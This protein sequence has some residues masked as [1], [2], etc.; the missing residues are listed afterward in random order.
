MI[1]LVVFFLVILILF[2]Y[3]KV[4]VKIKRQSLLSTDMYLKSSNIANML[5]NDNVN[6]ADL[7][8]SSDINVSIFDLDG[9]LIFLDSFVS[10][11]S[12]EGINL[13]D[14]Q[15]DLFEKMKMEKKKFMQYILQD[16]TQ[17]LAVGKYESKKYCII[18]Y[19]ILS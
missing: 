10:L 9:K 13:N 17:I 8:L 16:S 6:I 15:M 19:I 4:S 1:S 11:K 5:D 12:N 7:E 14:E 2:C 18:S 3:I